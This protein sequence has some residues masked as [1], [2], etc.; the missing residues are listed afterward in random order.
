VG[1]VKLTIAMI[2]LGDATLVIHITCEPTEMQFPERRTRAREGY[3]RLVSL[4][5]DITST[6]ME[7]YGRNRR[8]HVTI[9]GE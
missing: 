6:G 1:F 4:A 5:R 8:G 3:C 7:A 9:N 2:L